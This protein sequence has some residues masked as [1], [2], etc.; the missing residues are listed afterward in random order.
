MN[1]PITQSN[2]QN[3]DFS[4]IFDELYD[5]H[6]PQRRIPTLRRV[7]HIV[8]LPSASFTNLTQQVNQGYLIHVNKCFTATNRQLDQYCE[9]LETEKRHWLKKLRVIYFYWTSQPILVELHL[10]INILLAILED[11]P[12]DVNKLQRHVRA[13]LQNLKTLSKTHRLGTLK[14][15]RYDTIHLN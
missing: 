12:R 2:E 6:S 14:D 15:L 8:R 7:L 11:L 5:Q 13:L 1:L 9:E 3:G 10:H 4:T